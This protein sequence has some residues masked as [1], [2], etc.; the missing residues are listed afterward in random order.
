MHRRDFLQQVS[1]LS[2]VAVP[3]IASGTVQNAEPAASIDSTQRVINAPARQI[4][5]THDADVIV[6]GAT[7]G[8][9][10]GCFAAIMASR[11]DAD[12]KFVAYLLEEIAR[13]ADAECPQGF[14]IRFRQLTRPSTLELCHSP[15]FVK[16]ARVAAREFMR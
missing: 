12:R 10:G 4:P 15:A 2:A 9:L 5:I 7:L 6:V 3:A 14:S 11:P 16:S 1:S 8:G 13:A